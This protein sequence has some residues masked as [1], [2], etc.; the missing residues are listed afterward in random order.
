MNR[1]SK[2][3]F[4][5]LASGVDALYASSRP[6]ISDDLYKTLLILKEQ[7]NLDGSSPSYLTM[8][9]ETYLVGRSAWGKYPVFLEHEFARIGFT[10]SNFLPG[11]RLQIRSKFLH[12]LGPEKALLWFSNRLEEMGI[13]TYWTLSR[14]DL[15]TDL[16]GWNP[17]A[18]DKPNFLTRATN[19]SYHEQNDSFTG[20][21]FGIRNSG[22][23]HCRIYNKTLELQTKTDG[24]TQ[25]IWGDRV[26]PKIPVWRVEF[27][28]STSFLK[29]VGV[30]NA[31]DGLSKKSNLWAHFTE[32]WLTLRVPT[33]DSNK[34][35]WPISEPWEFIQN[36]SLRGSAIPIE[37]IR[38][39]QS[40]ASLESLLPP[41]RGYLTSLAVR[42]GATTLKEAFEA[43]EKYVETHEVRGKPTIEEILFF[44]KKKF[45]I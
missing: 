37:R 23:V 20:F 15:Y 40:N 32:N 43:T 26:D 16:Q 41:F 13:L 18:S 33:D 24:W 9:N 39:A 35:R 34:S 19:V 27:E 21:K 36:S 38:E 12:N 31:L 11:V 14:L 22:T 17:K 3:S 30:E 10:Q 45:F 8:G 7:S 2:S 25:L 5:E 6:L 42:L 29:Q 1:G 44:K 4:V 28:A